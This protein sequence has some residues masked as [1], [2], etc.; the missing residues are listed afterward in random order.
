MK[1]YRV[2]EIDFDARA[3]T[4]S[5]VIDPSWNPELQKEHRRQKELVLQGLMA[6]VGPQQFD[7]KVQNFVDIGPAPFSVVSFHNKFFRQARYAFV[8]GAY[9]PSLTAVCA[10]GER[11]LNHLIRALREDFITTP[12]YKR[13]ARKDSFDRWEVGICVLSA[14]GVLLPCAADLFLALRDLRNRALHFDP[15]VDTKDRSL[16]VEAVKCLSQIIDC[17]FSAFGPQPWYIPNQL[18]LSFVRK[19]SERQP[20][21]AWVILPSC[22]L[23]GPSHQLEVGPGRW[24][25][26]DPHVYPD[27]EVSDAE[28]IRLFEKYRNSPPTA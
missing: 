22:A 7:N 26:N 14:W 17:Q 21:V 15:T 10:L 12:E 19:D 28:F 3:N 2:I 23:V 4:I 8:I 18:G 24:K 20:F 6:E 5:L 25:V 13:V 16:S 27:R 11:I 1:R 9:Y